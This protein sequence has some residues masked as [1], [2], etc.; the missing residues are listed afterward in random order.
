MAFRLEII[1]LKLPDVKPGDDIA[2]LI[3]EASKREGVELRDGDVIVVAQKIVSKAEGR[4]VRLAD[5]T[6][7]SKAVELA[8]V[9]GKDPRLIEVILWDTVEV[10]K[11][12][13]GHLIVLNRQ[14]IVCAN[15]G[16][17]KS[18]VDGSGDTVVLLPEDPDASAH[19]I[20]DGIEA[21]T[22]R[23]VA[24]LVSDTYGRPLREGHIDMA[25][26]VAGF[27]IFRDY[28]GL[29][30]KYGYRLRVKRIA[31]ADE[32]ASAAELVMGNGAE[33]VPV[34]IVRGLNYAWSND[35][36]RGLNMRREKWLFT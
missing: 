35:S 29:T 28:R 34:A 15:A 23:R 36:A 22:G 7:S 9:T 2:R 13:R 8:E 14:G 27:P 33:G 19:R 4:I 16:V 26:G 20:R 25:I 1:G 32:V 12:V 30:D 18:N 10:V 3:V 24:V 21:L 17:D 5:V 31:I 6:P 11:A